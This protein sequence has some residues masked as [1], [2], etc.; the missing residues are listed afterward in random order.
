MQTRQRDKAG[1]NLTGGARAT[2]LQDG[3]ES[4]TWSQMAA[5]V[6]PISETG[7]AGKGQSSESEI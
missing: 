3:S 4:V 7:K 6:V 5:V 2:R 1:D